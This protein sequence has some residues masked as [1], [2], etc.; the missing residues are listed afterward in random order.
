MGF[1]LWFWGRYVEEEALKKDQFWLWQ[2]ARKATLY[3]VGAVWTL[4]AVIGLDSDSR[5]FTLQEPET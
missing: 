2:D 4:D 5:H 3:V 1:W